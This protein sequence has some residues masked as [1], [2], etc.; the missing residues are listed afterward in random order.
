MKIIFRKPP[1]CDPGAL[2]GK[3][4]GVILFAVL[5]VVAILLLVGYQFLNLMTV[6]YEAAH[7]AKTAG[8]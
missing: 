5:I 3:R 1:G 2:M 8:A 7:A 6:E 4:R